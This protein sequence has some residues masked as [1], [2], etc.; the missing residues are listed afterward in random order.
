MNTGLVFL[1]FVLFVRIVMQYRKTTEDNTELFY[2]DQSLEEIAKTARKKGHD[3]YET[4]NPDTK[5]KE[6][7]IVPEDGK[8]TLITKP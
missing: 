7:W 4:H 2:S 6:V 3:V 1:G 5:E 8:T